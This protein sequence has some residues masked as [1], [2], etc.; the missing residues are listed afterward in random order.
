M[1]RSALLQAFMV[2]WMTSMTT[3]GGD[4]T[5]YS[6]DAQG[7]LLSVTWPDGNIKRYHYE[8]GRFPR[9]LTGI[10]DETGQR[11][12]SYTYDAQGRV[13]ETQRASGVDRLQFS[14]G[15]DA[16]GAPQTTITDFSSGTPTTRTYNFVQ[17]GRVLRPSGVSSPCPLC[18]STARST[19]YDAAGRKIREVSHDGS[20]IFYTYNA[21]GQEAERATFP[22]SFSSA[23]TRPAL[24]N[25]TSVVSTMWHGTWNLPVRIAEP[26]RSTTY[27]YSNQALAAASTYATTDTTGALKFNG[28][29]TGPSASTQYGY[30]ANNL[31]TSITELTN[32][33]QT[34]RWNLTYNA[35]GDLIS[36]TDVTGGNAV[37]Q[38]TQVDGNG[39]VLAAKTIQGNEI[40]VTYSLRG[41]VTSLSQGGQ[42]TRYVQSPNGQTSLATMPNGKRLIYEYDS[43][44]RLVDI[45]LEGISLS[46][47]TALRVSSATEPS[48]R[49]SQ[50]MELL[51]RGLLV[52]IP[53]AHAQ[54]A[55]MPGRGVPVPIPGQESPGQ[56]PVS[57]WDLMMQS[58]G[59]RPLPTASLIRRLSKA[60]DKLCECDPNG[61][62]KPTLTFLSISK[63]ITSGHVPAV[64]GISIPGQ[65]AFDVSITPDQTFV[66]EVVMRAGK[67]NVNQ[68]T[69][70]LEYYVNN[71][72]KQT[73]TAFGKFPTKAVRLIVAPECPTKGSPWKPGEVVSFY[74]DIEGRIQ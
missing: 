40:R 54:V 42:L 26:G 3:P 55:L 59:Y 53:S 33:V 61:Y 19:Q 6:H 74:P 41:F 14:Y 60:L 22:A 7:N 15:Q 31:N 62:S 5:R 4:T 20:V 34:Q 56:P 63:M 13:S 45:K 35:A 27:S 32:G 46:S 70:N 21:A 12:G 44:Q 23:A 28:T 47:P 68:K 11:I 30:N 16:A 39:R 2:L 64:L 18:G 51:R 24:S 43:S 17:Q 9:A 36:I 65:S 1:K 29:A 52:S 71:M 69:G 8:D 37:A 49:L 38:V 66:D 10:T 67:P 58:E 73:G 48:T 72:G 57:A 50:L 25:A